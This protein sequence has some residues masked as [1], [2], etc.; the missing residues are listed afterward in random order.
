MAK[1][2]A[3]T[4]AERVCS[5]AIQVHGGYGYV[6]TSQWSGSTA[7]YA[8]ARSTRGHLIFSAWSLHAPSR[9]RNQTASVKSYK[10]QNRRHRCQSRSSIAKSAARRTMPSTKFMTVT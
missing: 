3:S 2:F 6:N 5:D 4:M 8:C 7:T 9:A 10:S 1:L